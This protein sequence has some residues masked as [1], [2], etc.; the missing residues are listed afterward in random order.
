MVSPRFY[1]ILASLLSTVLPLLVLVNTEAQVP[2]PTKS[3]QSPPAPVAF[4]HRKHVWRQW[5][6]RSDDE[7]KRDCQGCHDYAGVTGGRVTEN[8]ESS[9]RHCH[10]DLPDSRRSLEVSG[11]MAAT[12]ATEARFPTFRHQDHLAGAMACRDCHLPPEG[13]RGPNDKEQMW[14]P[15]GMGWCLRCHSEKSGKKAGF[16]VWNKQANRDGKDAAFAS[17]LNASPGMTFDRPSARFR[18]EDH[19]ELADLKAGKDCDRCHQPTAAA[20][21]QM[22]EN[23]FARPACATCHN[24]GGVAQPI[25]F[26]EGSAHEYESRAD[27][28]FYHLDHLSPEALAKS[29]SIRRQNCIACHEWKSMPDRDG[30]MS[31]PVQKQLDAYAGCADCHQREGVLGAKSG[32]RWSSLPD[33]GDIGRTDSGDQNACMACH[34]FGEVQSL[35]TW[36]LQVPKERSRPAAFR[37]TEQAHPHVTTQGGGVHSDCAKCHLAEIPVLTSRIGEKRFDHGPHLPPDGGTFKDCL[38]CHGQDGQMTSATEFAGTDGVLTYDQ[39]SCAR[40][41]RG[42]E[43]IRATSY[44]SDPQRSRPRFD[45]RDHVNLESPKDGVDNCS[46][47]HVRAK[48]GPH[49]DGRDFSYADQTLDCRAC[50]DHEKYPA[51]TG[52]GPGHEHVDEAYVQSCTE[53]HEKHEPGAPAPGV[54]YTAS[55]PAIHGMRGKQFHPSPRDQACADC[56]LLEPVSLRDDYPNV[57]QS[58]PMGYEPDGFHAAHG[59]PDE[60]RP[61]YCWA[62]HFG[63]PERILS[64]TTNIRRALTNG[65]LQPYPPGTK[66]TVARKKLG[67][68]IRGYPG[69]QGR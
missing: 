9:C 61:D 30:L 68:E 23:A 22:G 46:V 10:Y 45:H 36:R 31:F 4:P 33:H 51:R 63:R 40:C 27:L 11:T 28:T 20:S 7:Q 29:P 69:Y 3:A 34:A 62:C 59:E 38:E 17:A 24:E 18:H 57:V 64:L 26:G 1:L 47:C 58:T 44:P 56:H 2:P 6:E 42:V 49:L 50:H 41:H 35:E 8:P 15:T 52:G 21:A 13:G 55:H 67:G 53:C 48:D 12:R 16:E 54:V 5:Y 37:I 14:V 43:E 19:L 66:Y 32:A 65:S 60:G 25:Q 39:A